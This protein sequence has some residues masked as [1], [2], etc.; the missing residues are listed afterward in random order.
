MTMSYEVYKV[1]LPFVVKDGGDTLHGVAW[2]REESKCYIATER[3]SKKNTA[4]IK[5]ITVYSANYNFCVQGF[6]V[7]WEVTLAYTLCII[8]HLLQNT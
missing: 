8:T 7:R 5:R 2:A 4:K 3:A 1:P 6:S